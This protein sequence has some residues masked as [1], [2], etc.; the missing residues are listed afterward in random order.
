MT[1]LVDGAVW[2]ADDTERGEAAI[3][4]AFDG[5]EVAIKAVRDS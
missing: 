4:V 2:E 5:Y 1:T 3:H